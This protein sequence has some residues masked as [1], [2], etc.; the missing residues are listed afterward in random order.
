MVTAACRSWEAPLPP[1]RPPQAGRSAPDA[2]ALQSARGTGLRQVQGARTGA[3]ATV[4]PAMRD[5]HSSCRRGPPG[6][7]PS[8]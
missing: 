3:P 2:D 4:A 5:I 7:A 8:F 1:R 6:K